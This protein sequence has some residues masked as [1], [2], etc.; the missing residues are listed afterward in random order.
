DLLEHNTLLS[1]VAL[2][3]DAFYPVATESIG[4]FLR[5]GRPHQSGENVLWVRLT[6]DGFVKRKGFRVERK[7]VHFRE[8][9]RPTADVLRRWLVSGIETP[10]I[11]GQIEFSP[12]VSGE[13]LP[14]VHLGTAD[15]SASE[16][17]GY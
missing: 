2:P 5:K 13:W 17:D 12:L 16:F 15:L 6:D 1:V 14:Q 8:F 7:G 9:L 3:T 4:V 11:R 10:A